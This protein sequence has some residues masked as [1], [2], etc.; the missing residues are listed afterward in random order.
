M[1]SDFQDDYFTFL[2]FQTVATDPSYHAEMDKCANWLASYLNECGFSVEKWESRGHPPTLFATNFSAGDEKE[3]LLLYCHYDVQ[4]VDPLDLWETPPFEPNLRNGKIYA[5]GASDNKG[6]CFYTIC[7]LKT[8][9]KEHKCFPVNIKFVIEGEEESGSEGFSAILD[10]KK[11]QLKADHLLVIDSSIDS[12]K[13]PVITL[14]ARGIIGIELTIEESPHDLHSG[15]FGGI[16]YNPNRALVEMVSQLHDSTGTVAV[17]GFYDEVMEPTPQE[18]S[19][20]ATDFDEGAFIETYGFR[21][22]G[23]EDGLTPIEAS[24]FR[25]TLEINGLGGGYAGPG[26]KTVIPAK[27]VAK[28]SCRLVPRQTPARTLSLLKEFLLSRAPK[29]L[30]VKIE[31]IQGSGAGF[32]CSPHSRIAQIVTQSYTDVFAKPCEKILIGASIPIT[33]ALL[34][35]SGAEGVLIGTALHSDLIHSPNEHFSIES[36]EKGYRTIYRTLELFR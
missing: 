8:Y 3:T 1:F 27:A 28:I 12:L 24:W 6:Q 4:P 15:V 7:A 20:L 21:P 19:E 32:R 33:P 26:F 25:P 2:R 11:E 13:K 14:G 16:A 22:C 10:Q 5:R 17:P 9:F 18:V 34:K 23:M 35:T 29:G 31:S 30:N 36:F